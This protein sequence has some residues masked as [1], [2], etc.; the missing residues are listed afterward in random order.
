MGQIRTWDIAFGSTQNFATAEFYGCTIF[1]VVSSKWVI[2][3]H[4][5]QERGGTCPLDTKD[6]TNDMLVSDIVNQVPNLQVVANGDGCNDVF[7]VIMGTP[8]NL[9]NTGVP[10]FIEFFKGQEIPPEN[11]GYFQ[12]Q[13]T[14]GPIDESVPLS[15]AI[16]KSFIAWDSY[17][18]SIRGVMTVWFSSDEPRLTVTYNPDGT[19]AQRNEGCIVAI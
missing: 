6:G 19:S 13:A 10:T 5:R 14:G 4:I 11:I 7:V 17:D 2:I 1:A 8:R 3:G 12:Y 18:I 9:G 16:G 15:G